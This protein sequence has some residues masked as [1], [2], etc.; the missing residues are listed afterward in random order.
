ERHSL[1]W[2]GSWRSIQSLELMIQQQLHTKEELYKCS[3]CGM[4]FWHRRY[5]THQQ[6]NHTE[7]L[8]YKCLE[9][10]KSFSLS[11]HLTRHQNIH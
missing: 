7:E 6:K 11:S 3:E 5:L 10:G 4:R 9:C 2:E 8:P 1:C